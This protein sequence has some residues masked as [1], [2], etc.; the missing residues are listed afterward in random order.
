MKSVDLILII[1]LSIGAFQGIIYGAILCQKKSMHFYANRFLAA[2]L[3]FFSYR[4]IVETC[5]VFGYLRYDFWYQILLEYNWIYGTLL[6]FFVKSYVQ[7][8]FRLK[9]KD[10]IHFLPVII[11]IIWSFFIK[12][13]NFYWDGTRESLSWL[14]YYGYMAWMLYPT[15]Y[16]ISSMLLIYYTTRAQKLLKHLPQQVKYQLIQ[17]KLDWIN[18]VVR[19]IKI[20]AIVYVLGI[21]IDYFFFNFASNLFYGHP[22]FIGMA[23][24]TYWLGIEGFSRRKDEAFKIVQQL[25]DKEQKQL[26]KIA[27]GIQ[28]I[29]IEESLY[30]DPELTLSTLSRKLKTKPYLITKS[31]NTILQKKFTDYVNELRIEE[32]KR[33]LQDPKNNNYTLLALAYDA[34]FNSKASFNRAVKKITG[35]P[36]SSLKSTL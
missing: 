15:M 26:E 24:I 5:K 32:V 2:I 22:V 18:R 23:I 3:F 30:K 16:I 27:V 12:S 7:P 35:K 34:G 6:F 14:G 33:A 31:L 17:G 29:M 20:F 1:L 9:R 4:L 8:D 13:Q 10:Y 19:V 36:P 11:E 25:S 21:L 28:K